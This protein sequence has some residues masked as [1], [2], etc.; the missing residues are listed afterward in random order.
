MWEDPLEWVTL[1]NAIS[2]AAEDLPPPSDEPEPEATGGG[3]MMS[4]GV[5]PPGRSVSAED[6]LIALMAQSAGPRS[7]QTRETSSFVIA[8]LGQASSMAPALE[9]PS[10]TPC[11]NYQLNMMDPHGACKHC[12]HS[13]EA[14]SKH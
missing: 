3:M 12:G 6:D 14:C 8:G 1:L 13:K 4:E 11:G 5:P 10:A 7:S 9:G 2:D